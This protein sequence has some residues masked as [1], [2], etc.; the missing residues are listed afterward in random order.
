MFGPVS[1]NL[2]PTTNIVGDGTA[3]YSLTGKAAV[4]TASFGFESQW[5][6]Y[7][8]RQFNWRVAQLEEPSV[9]WVRIPPR[10]PLL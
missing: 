9:L 4:L 10:Q 6:V 2:T 5:D 1:S 8:C 7:S 3:D